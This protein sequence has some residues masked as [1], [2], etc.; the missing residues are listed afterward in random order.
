[1]LMCKLC[2]ARR[3]V[4]ELKQ[5]GKAQREKSFFL[6]RYRCL[7]CGATLVLSGDLCRPKY[8]V[9]CWRF[10][11]VEQVPRADSDRDLLPTLVGQIP[12]AKQAAWQ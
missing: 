4:Q 7:G 5:I 3:R 6:R 11:D 1:M 10:P 2:S 12:F 9:E 8:V